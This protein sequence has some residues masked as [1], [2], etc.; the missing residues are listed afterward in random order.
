MVLETRTTYFKK[1]PHFLID[2]PRACR[3]YMLCCIKGRIHCEIFLSWYFTKQFQGG[4]FHETLSWNTFTLASN[5]HCVCSSSIKKIVFTEKRYRLKFNSIK[6]YLLLI[7][8]K[9]KNSKIPKP[10]L[11]KPCSKTRSDRIA[12]ANTFLELPLTIEF[13]HYLGMNATSCH[14]SYIDF[15]TLITYDYI[16]TYTYNSDTAARAEFI[17]SCRSCS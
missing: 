17:S 5:I 10:I 6:K 1:E 2:E 9:Q 16:I 11:M 12:C 7:K 8:Q 15:Y 14:W 13:R 3:I 4:W